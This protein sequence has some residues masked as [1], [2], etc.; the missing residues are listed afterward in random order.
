MPVANSVKEWW[1]AQ[2]PAIT[3]EPE[4]SSYCS[5]GSF[6]DSPAP[7]IT[8]AAAVSAIAANDTDLLGLNNNYNGARLAI[9]Y[10]T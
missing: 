3:Q 8:T 6:K 9:A 2:W 1:S 4:Y 7:T 5:A 10:G